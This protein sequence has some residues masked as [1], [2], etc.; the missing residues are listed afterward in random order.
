MQIAFTAVDSRDGRPVDVLLRADARTP[1][2]E[3]ARALTATLRQPPLAPTRRPAPA[4]LTLA[5]H[6]W[7]LDPTLPLGASAVRDGA[8]VILDA[9]PPRRAAGTGLVDLVVNAGVGAGLIH[10]LA[11]GEHRVGI[12]PVGRVTLNE[13]GARLLAVVRVAA[14]GRCRVRAQGQARVTYPQPAAGPVH[15]IA[16]IRASCCLVQL[17]QP[18]PQP[19]APRYDTTGAT[20][21]HRAPRIRPSQEARSF[22]LP[23]P[24][25]QP[26]PA[27]IPVVATVLPMLAAAAV[28]LVLNS[29]TLLMFAALGP[30]SMIASVVSS[31]RRDRRAYRRNEQAHRRSRAEVH[32]AAR[33]ALRAEQH[34]RHVDHPGPAELFI[35]A[36][37]RDERLWQRRRDDPDYLHLRLGIATQPSTV[38]IVAATAGERPVRLRA[39]LPALLELATLG[40]AG[41]AGADPAVRALACWLVVQAAVL[42]SPADLAIW[43]LTST[44]DV[45]PA[46]SWIRWLPHCR[47]AGAGEAAL[48]FA[49][50]PEDCTGCVRELRSLL[51]GRGELP[52]DQDRPGPEVL[53]VLDGARALR[54]VPGLRELLR[55]GPAAGVVLL[56]LEQDD[57]DLPAECRAIVETTERQLI[58]RRDQGPTTADVLPDLVGPI[59]GPSTGAG[60][61][62]GPAG[63][64]G[65]LRWCESTARALAPLHDT[66]AD[67]GGLPASVHLVDLDGLAQVSAA[68][69]L[70]RWRRS[71]PGR[72]GRPGPVGSV[73]IGVAGGETFR[74]SLPDDG[75]HGLIAGTTG[76]GKSELL[77]TIIIAHAVTYRP[78][79][80]VFV[81]V[82]YKGGSAFA[83]CA[84]LPHTVGLVTDLDPHLVRR[85]L[86]SLSAELRRRET[87][88][89]ACSAK[90]LD[91][92]ARQPGRL[93]AGIVPPRLV[94]VVDEFATLAR[95]LP[96]FVAGLVNL[97]QR[98]RSLGLHLLL[99]TQRP[100]GVVSP[101]I[102]ANTNLRIALRVTDAHESDDV[103]G[104][105]DAALIG[106]STPGRAVLRTGPGR[107]SLV[108]T[109]WV[110]GLAARS[111]SADTAREGELPAP[112]VIELPWPWRGRGGAYPGLLPIQGPSGDAVGPS[113]GR[114]AG[115]T[116]DEPTDLSVLVR[117]VR[118]A[119]DGL[120]LPAPRSPWLPPL[121]ERFALPL[122]SARRSVRL[123]TAEALPTVPVGLADHC[124]RQCQLPFTMAVDEAGHLL[125]V[126]APRS[127]RSTA[128]R[129]IAGSI[130][131]ALSPHD[132]HLYG[133]DFGGGA[134][135]GLADLPHTGALVDRGDVDRVSRL[136]RRLTDL[137]AQRRRRFAANGAS[138]LREARRLTDAASRAPYL[139]VLVDGLEG[140]LADFE[141]VEGGDTVDLLLRL[142]REGPAA[143]ISVVLSADRRGLTGRFAALVPERLVLRMADPADGA[144]AGIPAADLPDQQPPG[145]GFVVGGRYPE[146]VEVQVGLLDPDPTGRAQSA[147]L[148]AVAR[149]ARSSNPGDVWPLRVEPLPERITTAQLTA[150]ANQSQAAQARP[151]QV[152]GGAGAGLRIPLGVGGDD[153]DVVEIDLIG[154]P[155]FVI[156]G[157]PRSGRSSV[158]LAFALGLLASGMPLVVVTPRPSPL[159]ALQGQRGVT[160]IADVELHDPV[161]PGSATAPPWAARPDG[162]AMAVLVD[163]AELVT[164]P[165]AS[166]LTEHW[167]HTRGATGPV[168]LAGL[169]EDLLVQ[170]RGFTVDLRRDGHGLLLAPRRATD[171]DL[172]GVRLSHARFGPSP[173]GRGLFV[174]HGRCTPVQIAYPGD[175]YLTSGHQPPA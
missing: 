167:R 79:E 11:A 43:I 129:T 64:A 48:R 80:L 74:L 144:L 172:L 105:P 16:T 119:A 169:T 85:A 30:V 131:D 165:I 164:E 67:D 20:S 92:L 18:V 94:L 12:T 125:V 25:S 49:V 150:A 44:A 116:A 8:V 162:H 54:A 60:W 24:P 111:G 75:P 45:A 31:R 96:D 50:G 73:P 26:R 65:T 112:E 22:R 159:R 9:A 155:A 168:V 86:T 55:V 57:R 15:I 71:S 27:P 2:R 166:A 149:R 87:L 34:Q 173:P 39:E 127:G 42:H 151:V 102:R 174:L 95:E 69:I 100:S 139:V 147:A 161:W 140:F 77:Q 32:R 175:P 142:L 114:P 118:A 76:A 106:R 154:N 28:A 163:D 52:V 5:G 148:R 153:L 133:L 13:P 109:A 110:G 170:Y 157:P 143:G 126:G 117:A 107:V 137:A 70:S 128:L 7:S 62:A 1:L 14:D 93:A 121:P 6:P 41:L 124:T 138:D 141:D 120:R 99:A 59:G 83:G 66:D 88:L 97:A 123:G 160:V 158:L 152:G 171:G 40:V 78:D 38:E 35:A 4:S 81:L 68:A 101:E 47:R 108:Q 84:A 36:W 113:P 19:S 136:L 10:S 103:V 33:A 72:P 56:C 89:A 145:R 91:A 134:L 53:V 156:G 90:D 37:R 61:Q 46:W 29:P 21:I 3:L 63:L 135:S 51:E 17:V 98:G 132:V 115:P 146:P 23:V 82:D 130:G 122:S 58:V 104:R